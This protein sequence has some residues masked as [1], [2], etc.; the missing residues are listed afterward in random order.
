MASFPSVRRSKFEIMADIL[1][2]G[3]ASLEDILCGSNINWHLAN[4]YLS[5]LTARGFL[6]ITTK[7]T[8]KIYRTTKE[9]DVLLHQVD[10]V[11]QRLGKKRA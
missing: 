7:G 6:T 11:Y 8:H 3:E 9:G 10:D 4:K 1:R 2:L 5:L